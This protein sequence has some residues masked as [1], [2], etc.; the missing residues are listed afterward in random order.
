LIGDTA[1]RNVRFLV[2]NRRSW[3]KGARLSQP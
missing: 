3:R 1:P 2:P